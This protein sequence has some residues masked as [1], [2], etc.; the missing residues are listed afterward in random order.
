MKVLVLIKIAEGTNNCVENI[1]T[2]RDFKI[3]IILPHIKNEFFFR[4][5][6][7][8]HSFCFSKLCHCIGI[9]PFLSHCNMWVL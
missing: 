9:V 1:K 4:F 2:D 7:N 8:R 5:V 3:K 6:Q